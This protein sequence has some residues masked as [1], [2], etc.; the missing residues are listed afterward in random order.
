LEARS[1]SAVGARIISVGGGKGGVGKS[2][3]SS[4][5]AV[6]MA[7]AGKRVVLCDL[8]LGA[9]NLHLMFGI[10]KPKPGIAQ[11]LAPDGR[12][13][14]ALTE[15]KLPN[16]QLLSG[17]GGT[18]HSA[19]ISHGEKLRIIRKL[20]ALEADIVLI[21]V[22]A[23]VGYNV[24]D[25]FELGSQ[26]LVVATPQVTSIHDAYA[27]LKGAVLRTLRHHAERAS[28]VALLEPA[29]TSKEGEKISEMLARIHEK[30]P[31]FGAKVQR[32]LKNFGAY[33][34]GNQVHDP[35][36]MGVFQAVSKMIQDYL[37][38]EVPIL[39]WVRAQAKIAESVNDRSP[40]LLRPSQANTEE[41]RAFRGM[42]EALLAS[43]GANEEELLVELDDEA[44]EAAGT[45]PAPEPG[46][47]LVPDDINVRAVQGGQAM[48][49]V[50]P[51]RPASRVTPPPVPAVPPPVPAGPPPV[52]AGR[53]NPTPRVLPIVAAP[54][55]APPPPPPAATATSPLKPRVYVRPPRKDKAEAEDE[56]ANAARKR[57]RASRSRR[58][59]TLPGMIPIRTRG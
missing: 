29:S 34:I 39:G 55:Q 5:L 16:L 48:T 52:P 9:A 54:R 17:A 21:D 57:D 1:T 2:I 43:E 38:L 14:D 33:L 12:V 22:G 51:Q 3:I 15:T 10:S 32:I 50:E 8:D 49:A 35:T 59:L 36:Q 18:V 58:K 42:V 26:R 19:N 7:Q 27:F 47:A 44:G 20:R 6:A 37:G 13:Y 25:F 40:L 53:S 23:G 24:L 45:A 30:D 4:N 46:P 56:A 28:D 11:L 31:A 41:G